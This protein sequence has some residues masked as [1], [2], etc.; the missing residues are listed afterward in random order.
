M[1]KKV[2]NLIIAGVCVVVLVAALIL[3][4]VFSGQQDQEDTASGV[5]SALVEDEVDNTLIDESV[6]EL[7]YLTVQGAN[8]SYTVRMAPEPEEGEDYSFTIDEFTDLPLDRSDIRSA[9]STFANASYLDMVFEDTTGMDLSAYGLSQPGTTITASFQGRVYTMSL[10]NATSGVTGRYCILEGDPA[11]YVVA[12]SMASTLDV[13]PN[14]YLDKTILEA[15]DNTD[16]DPSI[17]N[18]TIHR[19]DLPEDIVVEPTDTSKY[20]DSTLTAA[21]SRYELTSPVVTLVNPDLET[22][23]LFNIFGSEAEDVVASNPTQQQLEEY[24][25]ASPA[26]EVSMSWDETGSLNLTIGNETVVSGTTCRY[27]MKD[28]SPL[29]YVVDEELLPWVDYTADDLVSAL[30]LV[31]YIQNVSQ[32][33]ISFGGNEYTFQL[34]Q[35][36]T[37]T[38]NASGQTSTETHVEYNGTALDSDNFAV[39]YQLVMSCQA[40]GINRSEVTSDPI[41]TVTYLYNNGS[42]DTVDYYDMGNRVVV[43]SV[44]GAQAVTTSTSFTNKVQSELQKLLNG[45]EVN[46]NW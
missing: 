5:T 34:S 18:L 2:R 30:P 26:A 22:E 10:G 20:G 45:E 28:G 41:M 17:T 35:V 32:M 43:V 25:L 46:M 7:D 9:V 42:T 36:S 3:L 19:P 23:L 38:T 11:L 31:P 15:Y 8:G 24:G 27:V 29:V 44:N 6:E 21:S 33:T 14:T 4:L 39:W 1:N 37:G 12:N 16:E 40:D 13:N